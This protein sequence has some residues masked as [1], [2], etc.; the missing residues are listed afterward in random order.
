MLG[1]DALTELSTALAARTRAAR[2][3]VAE[4]RAGRAVR[5]GTL[6]RDGVVVASE[7]ALPDADSFDVVHAQGRTRARLAGRDKGTNVAVLAL[8]GTAS[9]AELKVA[10]PQ[11]GA[12]AQAIGADGYGGTTSRLGAISLVGPAWHSRVGGRIDRRI[13]LDVTLSNSDEGGPVL[14]SSGDLLGISTLGPNGRVLVIPAST[15]ERAIDPLL[16]QG[17]IARGWL[18]LGL[19]TVAVPD[20]LR[21]A[22]GQDSG[23]MVMS[24][25]ADSPAASAGI[26]LGDT[27]LQL[28]GAPVARL[29][30]LAERLG[31]E[32]VGQSIELNLIRAGTVVSTTVKIAARPNDG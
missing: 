6:W 17:R 18:G 9:A 4:I 16:S 25:A 3:L 1:N 20:A 31:P 32:S 7:Q 28:S 15:I 2:P 30:Q 22:S 29:R 8:D 23:L 11:V 27:I 10:E 12:L 26:V 24:V 5:T 21:G 14:D 13:L 19:Q